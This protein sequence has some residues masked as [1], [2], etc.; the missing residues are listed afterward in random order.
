MPAPGSWSA[1]ARLFLVVNDPDQAARRRVADA[2]TRKYQPPLA[3]VHQ[4][5]PITIAAE[6]ERDERL[7]RNLSA[8]VRGLTIQ[9]G[10]LLHALAHLRLGDFAVLARGADYLSLF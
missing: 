4:L 1:M 6:V 10:H 5:V 8:L 2:A 9:A 3:L 7:A